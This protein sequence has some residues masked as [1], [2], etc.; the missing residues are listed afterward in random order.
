LLVGAAP[1][2]PYSRIWGYGPSSLLGLL[3]VVLIVLMLFDVVAAPWG[4]HAVVVR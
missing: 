4:P 3:L 1:A 2:W